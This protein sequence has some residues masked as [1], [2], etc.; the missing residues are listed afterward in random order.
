MRDNIKA[1]NIMLIPLVNPKH[2]ITIINNFRSPE[3]ILKKHF[4]SIDAID[5]TVRE[6]RLS[7]RLMA[8]S[9]VHAP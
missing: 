4:S 9:P 3:G 1:P 8:I 7:N 2:K 6:I 5:N